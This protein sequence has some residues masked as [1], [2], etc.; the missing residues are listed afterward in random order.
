MALNTRP[1]SLIVVYLEG[2]NHTPPAFIRRKKDVK[3]GEIAYR[4]INQAALQLLGRDGVLVASSCSYHLPRAGLQSMLNQ[5]AR[6]LDRN[7]QI[8]E[9]GHQGRDHPIHP[10]IA[11][12]EYLK[13]IIGRVT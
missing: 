11:E 7:L 8:L 6:H 3:E 1:S 9:H 2:P 12:T 13:T 4:R 10:A 5:S